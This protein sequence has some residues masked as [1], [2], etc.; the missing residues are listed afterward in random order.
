MRCQDNNNQDE[1]SYTLKTHM[2]R[3]ESLIYDYDMDT[4]TENKGTWTFAK[5]DNLETVEKE[6][7]K[8]IYCPGQE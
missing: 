5:N 7:Q 8:E 6:N 3:N 2:E 4:E 1:K